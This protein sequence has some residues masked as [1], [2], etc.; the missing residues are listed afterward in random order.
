MATT[1]GCVPDCR[2]S[3]LTKSRVGNSCGSGPQFRD[4]VTAK[5]PFFSNRAVAIIDGH[6]S[7]LVGFGQSNSLGDR[8][9][10]ARKSAPWVSFSFL[11]H[12][13]TL[14][15]RMNPINVPSQ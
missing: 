3:P 14:L 4:G 7:G 10:T 5:E 15:G 6:F 13:P 11:C 2:D 1:T 9:L 12:C 8:L